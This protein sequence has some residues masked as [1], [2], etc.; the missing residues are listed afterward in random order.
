[1]VFFC[2]V[3]FEPSTVYGLNLDI[4]P[5]TRERR[6]RAGAIDPNHDSRV[7]TEIIIDGII[8]VP[9]QDVVLTN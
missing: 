6:Y 3:F 9:C 5:P 4:K 7:L 2:F 1:M 8:G